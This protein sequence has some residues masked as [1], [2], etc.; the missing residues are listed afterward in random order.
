MIAV[1]ERLRDLDGAEAVVMGCA[2]MARHRRPLEDALGVALLDRSSR[3][4]ETTKAG[5]QFLDHVERVLAELERGRGHV[6]LPVQFSPFGWYPRLSILDLYGVTAVH[7]LLGWMLRIVYADRLE[8]DPDAPDYADKATI[9]T[10]WKAYLSDRSHADDALPERQKLLDAI[11]IQ[12]RAIHDLMSREE[13]ELAKANSSLFEAL[14][15]FRG[16]AS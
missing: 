16:R 10:W 14:E 8:K 13:E 11:R 15:R 9:E 2:G 12:L 6:T 1:G 4:V 3:H 7:R 5:Q